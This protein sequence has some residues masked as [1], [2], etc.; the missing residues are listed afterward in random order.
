M[1]PPHTEPADEG[2]E[3]DAD[4]GYGSHRKGERPDQIQIEGP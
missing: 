2:D 3:E 1:K 4:S